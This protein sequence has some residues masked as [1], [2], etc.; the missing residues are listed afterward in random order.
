MNDCPNIGRL[1]ALLPA[2]PHLQMSPVLL[3]LKQP[4]TLV[5]CGECRA[6]KTK[7][8]GKRPK[9]DVCTSRD[10]VCQCSETEN[11]QRRCCN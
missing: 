6:R 11:R 1:P 7:C 5:A 9:C 8:N 4:R 2:P 3:Q 10:F